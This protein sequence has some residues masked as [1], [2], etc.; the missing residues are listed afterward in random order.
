MF[1]I[2]RF[3]IDLHKNVTQLSFVVTKKNVTDYLS[4]PTRS[5]LKSKH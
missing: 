2:L 1:A 5:G 4:V 3:Y